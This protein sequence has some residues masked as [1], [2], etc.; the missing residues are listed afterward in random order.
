M[1]NKMIARILGNILLVE[2]AL[3]V[4]PLAVSTLCREPAQ[5]FLI[6]IA[7]LLVCGTLLSRAAPQSR[8]LYA[9][10]GLVIVALAWVVVSLFGALLIVRD[11]STSFLM[12]LYAAPVTGLSFLLGYLLPLLPLALI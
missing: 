4:V 7:L 3:L 6:P 12:R 5:P 1:N 11:R 10:E 9:R 2:A 8:A